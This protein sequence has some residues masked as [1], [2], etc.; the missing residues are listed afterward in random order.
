LKDSNDFVQKY[1]TETLWLIGLGLEKMNAVKKS[2]DEQEKEF[3]ILVNNI[4]KRKV[5]NK[6]KLMEKLEEHSLFIC[7]FI[8]D[9]E[10]FNKKTIRANTNLM[11]FSI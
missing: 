7:G 5:L 6:M 9:K 8:S 4:I 10:N 3:A 1:L 11:Y 2:N